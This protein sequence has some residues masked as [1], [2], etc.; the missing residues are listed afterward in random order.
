MRRYLLPTVLVFL[1][2]FT[3]PANESDT[4]S[5]CLELVKEC[6]SFADE[7]RDSC[8]QRASRNEACQSDALGLLAAKRAAFS[9][10]APSLGDGLT[11]PQEARLVDRE[12]VLNFDNFLLSN[13]VNGPITSETLGSL[14]DVLIGC[15][16]S[17]SHDIMRP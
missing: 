11:V 14:N 3:S 17:S 7:S 9:S 16:K 15:A 12:C 4:S 10:I 2:G 5:E 6:F 13:L 1:A 8:F